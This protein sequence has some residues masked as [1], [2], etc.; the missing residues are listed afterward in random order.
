M[1]RENVLEGMANADVP[2]HKVTEALRISRDSSR[3]SVFQAMFALQERDW[4]SVDD[5][6]PKEGNIH[7]KLKQ[8]NHNTSKFEVHLQLRHDGSDGLEG[9]L[10]IATD[11]FTAQSGERM[12]G[13]Y[14]NLM[15]SCI[16][17]SEVPIRFHDITTQSD[18][19]IVE[20]S[21]DTLAKFDRFSI[22]ELRSDP[23]STAFVAD[24][25]EVSH[26]TYG[27]F[28]I[29]ISSVSSF[30]LSEVSVQRQDR[31][32]LL[33]K[34]SPKAVAAIFGVINAGC[35]VVILDPEK[36]PL[37]RCD[38]IFDDASVNVVLVDIEF[39]DKFHHL[40]IDNKRRLVNLQSVLEYYPESPVDP[41]NVKHDD[42]FGIFY[43]SGTTGIPKGK[44]RCS[45][46]RYYKILCFIRD[47]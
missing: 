41:S 8:F 5:L 45:V 22:L 38:M 7:F 46:A 44:D 28:K 33:L 15:R 37:E 13:M 36:T 25:P 11:L 24:G 20:A 39:Q 6:N 2:F 40:Q 19:D 29:L 16:D 21:N 32:G 12:V 35:T 9:D 18:K 43:T 30:L 3:T 34:S 17:T 27:E 14:K 26:T 10:H 31:V 47:S 1:I 42:V 4:H 23:D